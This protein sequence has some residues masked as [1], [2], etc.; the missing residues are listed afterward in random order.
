M[1]SGYSR[2]HQENTGG[3]EIRVTL[4]LGDKFRRDFDYDPDPGKLYSSR[5]LPAMGFKPWTYDLIGE[6]GFRDPEVNEW[7][8]GEAPTYPEGGLVHNGYRQPRLNQ[9]YEFLVVLVPSP[10]ITPTT[11][12]GRSTWRT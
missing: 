10:R 1:G 4:T 8:R 7:V 12:A 2:M 11:S 6:Y 9:P 5:G 3:D